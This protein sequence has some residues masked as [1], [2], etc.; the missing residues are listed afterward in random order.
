MTTTGIVY[1]MLCINPGLWWNNSY[2]MI[3]AVGMNV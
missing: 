2:D 1:G 3:P